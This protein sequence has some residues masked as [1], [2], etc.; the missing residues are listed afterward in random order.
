MGVASAL[1]CIGTRGIGIRISLRTKALEMNKTEDQA[2]VV[3][4]LVSEM[5][6]MQAEIKRLDEALNRIASKDVTTLHEAQAI[7]F[8]ALTAFA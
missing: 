6:R 5:K 7:A 2:A 4:R 8:G 1:D 3:R